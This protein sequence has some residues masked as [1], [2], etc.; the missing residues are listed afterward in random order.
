M[1]RR[2]FDWRILMVGI[3]G[4]FLSAAL[5]ELFHI[6]LHW[7]H[8]T[9]IRIFPNPSA[10]VEID[11][12]MT[13]NYDLQF[14]ETIAYSITFA[15]V[16]ITAIIMTKMVEACDSRTFSETLLPKWSTMSDLESQELVELAYK[17]NAFHSR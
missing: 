11:A 16:L 8:I 5:H 15:V 1:K 12:A 6:A 13:P 14:E 4:L 10:I 17:S 7:G 9:A 3:I 2:V